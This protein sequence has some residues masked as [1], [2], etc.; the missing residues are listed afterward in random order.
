M[1][2]T[3][4]IYFKHTGFPG[5]WSGVHRLAGKGKRQA[6]EEVLA[7]LRITLK[8]FRAGISLELA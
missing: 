7:K 1:R 4:I 3:Q 8:S 2:R 5:L 6:R